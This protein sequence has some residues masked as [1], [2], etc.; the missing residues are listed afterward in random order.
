M[1]VKTKAQPTHTRLAFWADALATLK[2][3]ASWDERR[4]ALCSLMQ[5]YNGGAELIEAGAFPGSR[6][7]N[8]VAPELPIAVNGY[9]A[10]L[11]QWDCGE[12]TGIHGH[13]NTMFVYVISAEL[14]SI[15]F[16][17]DGHKLTA[18]KTIVSGPG[19]TFTGHAENNSFDNF[20]HQLRCIRPGW[21]LHVY[22]DAPEHGARF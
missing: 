3:D 21:S 17:L 18:G 4:E 7:P 13:P 10:F 22:S 14:E 6:S 1:S 2:Q 11:K 20:I 19:E 15:G 12:E 5:Q 8:S 16:K 9:R